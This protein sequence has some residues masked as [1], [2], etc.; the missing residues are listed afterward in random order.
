MNCIAL[1]KKAV[2]TILHCMQVHY[3]T[4]NFAL[5]AYYVWTIIIELPVDIAERILGSQSFFT[6]KDLLNMIFI[7]SYFLLPFLLPFHLQSRLLSLKIIRISDI[8]Y[9][10]IKQQ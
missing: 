9:K 5:P 6:L 7:T 8:K 3:H 10:T 4:G 2:Q 1:G